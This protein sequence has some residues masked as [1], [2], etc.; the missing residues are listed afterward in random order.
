MSSRIRKETDDQH[1]NLF[2]RSA[3]EMLRLVK[4]K[5][6]R[7]KRNVSLMSQ[8]SLMNE[9]TQNTG[10]CTYIKMHWAEN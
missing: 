9:Y 7:Q 1:K 2:K 5:E 6:Q 3:S 8:W 10:S 4:E